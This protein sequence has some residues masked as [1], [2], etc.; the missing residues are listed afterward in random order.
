MEDY[1]L[2]LMKYSSL[3]RKF[4]DQAVSIF[5][6]LEETEEPIDFPD[7]GDLTNINSE[8]D[9]QAH[10]NRLFCS[11]LTKICGKFYCFD[12]HAQVIPFIGN[13]LLPDITVSFL[14]TDLVEEFP[15]CFFVEMKG[16]GV[17]IT[18]PEI[19]GQAISY[20]IRLLEASSPK[21]RISAICCVTNLVQ[22]VVVQVLRG[23]TSYTVKNAICS[24]KRALSTLFNSSRF[25]LGIV[26]ERT[27]GANILYEA[28]CYQP[29]KHLGTGGS[30]VV[31]TSSQ[32]N[33]C[34][35]FFYIENSSELMCNEADILSLMNREKPSDIVMQR[36]IGKLPDRTWPCLILEPIGTLI[37]P[38]SCFHYNPQD[39]FLSLLKT[40]LYAH[41]RGVLHNDIRPEN[42]IWCESDKEWMLIDWAAAWQID[43]TNNSPREY[44]GCVT[45]ASDQILSQLAQIRENDTEYES[46]CYQ[47]NASR[48]TD[49]VAF[50]RCVFLFCQRVSSEGYFDLLKKRKEFDFHGV[51]EWW[52][53]YLPRSW[54][55]F[56]DD[57]RQQFEENS[58]VNVRELMEERIMEILPTML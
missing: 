46:Q 9:V 49:L 38:H 19:K 27:I 13:D 18:T 17:S 36:L 40:L 50:M 35:K 20:C 43:T 57:L 37:K 24:P 44:R 45:C 42:I 2:T 12:T 51:M 55:K 32:Y 34:L 15:T 31:F 52:D 3:G 22:A 6:I 5:E 4:S 30:A 11:P 47:V 1:S 41:S 33:R 28:V 58:G 53:N 39:A 56:E 23:V 16:K 54:K 26:G 14:P 25:S 21:T 10:F 8:K 48:L 7:F 29:F